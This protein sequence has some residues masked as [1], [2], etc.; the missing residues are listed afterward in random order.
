MRRKLNIITKAGIF[1]LAGFAA[2]AA[3]SYFIFGQKSMSNFVSIVI[4]AAL[5]LV[6]FFAS[7]TIYRL[8]AEKGS[9]FAVKLIF[10]SF[11]GK[12]IIIAVVFFLF[13][14]ISH[15]NP[16]YFFVSF[17]IFFTILLNIEI[18]L[19]YKKVLFKK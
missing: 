13:V 16:T 19:I 8:L 11:F 14:K 2:V 5:T 6:L 18:Y 7:I 10:L 17:V 3:A 1:S 15:V 12:L 9:A 4:A